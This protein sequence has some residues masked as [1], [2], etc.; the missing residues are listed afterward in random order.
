[1]RQLVLVL[2]LDGDDGDYLGN[3]LFIGDVLVAHRRYDGSGL[4]DIT[5]EISRA[6]ARM[7]RAELIRA[8]HGTFPGSWS[9]NRPYGDEE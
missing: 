7:L 8:P 4:E 2:T 6:F 1:M 9:E 5:Q 3:D